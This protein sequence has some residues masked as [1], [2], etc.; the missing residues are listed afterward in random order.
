MTTHTTD[1]G[2][3]DPALPEWP[4]TFAH[5]E[6]PCP[7]TDAI[8]LDGEVFVLVANPQP[9]ADDFRSALQR[10]V[11][12][13][14]PHPLRAGL[15]CALTAT[16]LERRRKRVPRLRDHHVAQA[17]LHPVHGKHKQT[18]DDVTHYTM[19]LRTAA[20]RDAPSLFST[21]G[22]AP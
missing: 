13:D 19:W 18:T 14:K 20:L 12:L 17:R 5:P 8:D 15:S 1:D 7:P 10:G 4:E 21:G 11:F 3:R 6:H 9:T 22:A 2:N 16:A